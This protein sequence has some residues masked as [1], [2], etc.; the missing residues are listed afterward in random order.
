MSRRRSQ[1]KQAGL[2]KQERAATTFLVSH[3]LRRTR[4]STYSKSFRY[5]HNRRQIQP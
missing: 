1:I 3:R 5:L 2:K 4:L